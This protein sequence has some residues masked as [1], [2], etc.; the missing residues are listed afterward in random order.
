MDRGDS[1]LSRPT[2][3]TGPGAVTAAVTMTALVAFL[4]LLELVDQLSNNR[5]DS[6]GIEARDWGDLWSIFTAP[7]MHAGW[8][9]LAGN[10]L[11]LWIFGFLV[12]LGGGAEFLRVALICTITSGLAAWLLSPSLSNTLG[13]SGVIFGFLTYLLMRGVY[14]RSGKQIGL[15]VVLLLAFG[16]LLWGVLPGVPGVSWQGH[17]GGAVGGVIAAS[18]LRK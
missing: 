8:D 12:L 4:W 16:G 6:L 17:L 15:A 11:P 9:H 7:F 18:R 10:S 14:T 13:A 3:T 1:Y 5:L 2:Q